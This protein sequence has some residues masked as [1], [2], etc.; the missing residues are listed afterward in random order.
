LRR[1]LD[2]EVPRLTLAGPV[3]DLDPLDHVELEE[4]LQVAVD[5]AVP[6]PA[7]LGDA[8]R[9]DR[10]ARVLQHQDHREEPGLLHARGAGLVRKD[11]CEDA[12]H[13]HANERL[14]RC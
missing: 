6:L 8:R 1:R 9:G 4:L 11:L 3:L 2:L 13:V 12:V 5:L 10:L 14:K 7:Q